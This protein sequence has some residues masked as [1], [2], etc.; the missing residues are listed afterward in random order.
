VTG[1]TL[2]FFFGRSK[3][4]ETVTRETVTRETVN[5][6]RRQ[7]IQKAYEEMGARASGVP[8]HIFSVSTNHTPKLDVGRLRKPCRRAR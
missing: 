7:S 2:F 4:R 3:T 1:L 5:S 8:W 6:V